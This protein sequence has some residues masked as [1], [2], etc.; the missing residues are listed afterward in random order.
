MKG[1]TIARSLLIL[2]VA[3]CAALVSGCGVSAED[4]S[5]AVRTGASPSPELGNGDAAA[6]PHVTV[7][8]VRGDALAPVDRRNSGATAEAALQQVVEGPT[9]AEAADGIRTAL[10]PEVDGVGAVG[11]DGIATVTVSRG[12][13]GITGGNQLLAV[14]QI[15][16]TLTDLPTV[17]RVR[18]T[19]E[20]S[21]IEVPTDAGLSA[22]PVDR[23]D[24][25]SVAP[26]Q[27]SP[28]APAMGTTGAESGTA[29][30]TSTPPS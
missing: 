11:L 30:D 24:F 22:G 18:F 10:A 8:F 23:E 13:T 25:R 5:E 17:D 7:F 28:V 12:F 21:P 15:V 14:A 29:G 19:V 4:T 6:G 27:P 9:R 3:L 2:L 1:A 20:G 16:W 26:S